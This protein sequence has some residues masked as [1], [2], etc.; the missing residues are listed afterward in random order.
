MPPGQRDSLPDKR[1]LCWVG[2]RCCNYFRVTGAG[3]REPRKEIVW[4][5]WRRF[6]RSSDGETGFT[7]EQDC[8]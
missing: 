7:S 4:L 8:L 3:Y 6:L 2:G 5:S 1:V